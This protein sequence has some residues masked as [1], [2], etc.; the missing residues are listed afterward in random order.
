MASPDISALDLASLEHFRTELVQAGFEP[1]PQD[2]RIW[3]GPIAD[4]LKAFT[5]AIKM[6]IVF[7]DG[8][9]FVHPRLEVDCLDE[10]HVGATGEICLWRLGVGTGEWLTFDGFRNRIRKWAQ[11]AKAGFRPEDFALDAHLF[12]GRVLPNTI[13]L[14]ELEK[15][16][17]DANPDGISVISGKW[18]KDAPCT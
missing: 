14:V 5:S 16:S 1:T 4:P 8:W 9:P 18:R 3:V 11:R 17:V 12:F 13:A 2:P 15:L 7:R 10:Q 6:R